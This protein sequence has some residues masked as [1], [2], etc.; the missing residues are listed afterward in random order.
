MLSVILIILTI[1]GWFGGLYMLER[2]KNE[3]IGI[4]LMFISGMS[5]LFHSI[6]GISNLIMLTNPYIQ[7]EQIK[8][9]ELNKNKNNDYLID[10]IMEWNKDVKFGKKYQKDFWIG[11]YIPNIYD[12]FQIIETN[13]TSGG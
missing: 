13:E 5:I 8:Y 9:E 2:D 1:L 4:I 3:F 10:D 11:S 7:S 12:D 6:I